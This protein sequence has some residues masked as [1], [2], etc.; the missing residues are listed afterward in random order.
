[1][2]KLRG[3]LPEVRKAAVAVVGLAAQ[4]LAMGLFTGRSLDIA[5]AI[6]SLGTA[7]GVYAVPNAQAAGKHAA[8]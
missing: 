1:M 5:T 2:T 7:V 8:P 6:V 4:G 3:I